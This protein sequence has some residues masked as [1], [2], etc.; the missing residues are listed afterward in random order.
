MYNISV[1]ENVT[2]CTLKGDGIS[3]L[4]FILSLFAEHN[5]NIDMI[6]ATM[7]KG[8]QN[9]FSFSF[10]D[11]DFNKSM[12]IIKKIKAENPDFNSSPTLSMGN[13]KI[14]ISGDMENKPG[15]AY[16]ILDKIKDFDIFI[17]TT[18]INEISLLCS[19]SEKDDILKL[20]KV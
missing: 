6:S 8:H 17:I 12:E 19:S 11:D 15:I 7:S 4:S 10:M 18:A 2:L 1:L 20:L 5:I 16:T 13:C 14:V 3:S 9:I